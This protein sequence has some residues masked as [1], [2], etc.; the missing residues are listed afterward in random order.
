MA[1]QIISPSFLRIDSYEDVKD[2]A[3]FFKSTRLGTSE[4]LK[5]ENV[6]A[7]NQLVEAN[8]ALRQKILSVMLVENLKI[9]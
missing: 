8:S 4:W 7:D 5:F 2:L 9:S 6:L 1:E 3:R